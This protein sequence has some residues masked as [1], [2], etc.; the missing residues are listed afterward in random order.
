MPFEFITQSAVVGAIG[1]ALVHF[2]WQGIILAIICKI[3][4]TVLRQRSSNSRYLFSLGILCLMC[5]SVFTTA[6][7]AYQS[8]PVTYETIEVELTAEQIIYSDYDLDT[9]TKLALAP[10]RDSSADG[11]AEGAGF[12]SW[13]VVENWLSLKLHWLVVLWLAGVLFMS[14]YLVAG[15]FRTQRFKFEDILPVSAELRESVDKLIAVIGIDVIVEVFESKRVMVPSVIGWAKPV[16]LLP[17]SVLSGLSTEQLEA[18]LAHELAHIKRHDYLVNLF[19]TAVEILLFFHPATWWVS[20]HI[21]LEREHCCDDIAVEI[22]GDV[23][24]YVGALAELETLKEPVPQLAVAASGGS[25]LT[26]V[27]RLV[28]PSRQIE[29]RWGIQ[30]ASVLI[31]VLLV[32]AVIASAQLSSSDNPVEDLQVLWTERGG[33]RIRLA[34]L[35]G[36]SRN[37][38]LEVSGRP[39]DIRLDPIKENIYWTDERGR[40]QRSHIDNPG[41][42]EVIVAQRDPILSV[43]LDHARGEIYW[44]Q[45]NQI[46]KAKL[47]GSGDEIIVDH[48]EL[49]SA[50]QLDLD[51]D[52]IYWVDMLSGKVQSAALDGSDLK[53]IFT[54]RPMPVGLAIDPLRELIFWSEIDSRSIYKANLDGSNLQEVLRVSGTPLGVHVD[55]ERAKLYWTDRDR[56]TLMRSNLDGS[57]SELLFRDLENPFATLIN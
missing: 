27:R 26:R 46:I 30:S 3:G 45:P 39:L 10:S 21:R 38:S 2:V 44:A 40:I 42:A 29:F 25:L 19:Q 50:I 11:S 9:A 7:L 4:L 28:R 53:T 48:L 36:H 51:N 1:W 15:F 5:L 18:I 49:P 14:L 35:E 57:S 41:V 8:P 55:S 34:H 43:A 32:S 54:G 16:I 56:G 13:R 6:V 24:T 22:C 52:R 17:V 47:D 23:R 37:V 33:D 12:L 31:V 20:S